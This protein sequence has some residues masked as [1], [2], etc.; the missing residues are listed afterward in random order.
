VPLVTPQTVNVS[1][2]TCYHTRR[3]GHSAPDIVAVIYQ[4]APIFKVISPIRL[5]FQLYKGKRE[6]KLER[7]VNKH[8]GEVRQIQMSSNR[9]CIMN[10]FCSVG[11]VI[12]SYISES[13]SGIQLHRPIVWILTALMKHWL[14]RNWPR[15]K[16][17]FRGVIP[18]RVA[19]KP[20]N[21]TSLHI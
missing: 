18:T 2:A 20:A 10:G 13:K 3:L 7:V 17:I 1:N 5:S 21:L 4:H 16:M 15:L 14:V 11:T 12:K 9:T 6:D 8:D 19:Q